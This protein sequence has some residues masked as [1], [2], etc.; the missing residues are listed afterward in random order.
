MN[1]EHSQGGR[2]QKQADG[3]AGMFGINQKEDYAQVR[4]HENREKASDRAGFGNRISG[5]HQ[6]SQLMGIERH[7]QH[8]AATT[9]GVRKNGERGARR[10]RSGGGELNCRPHG[11]E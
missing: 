7:T 8:G 10:T 1:S 6:R 11:A 2:N 5:V 9:G 3:S 4:E